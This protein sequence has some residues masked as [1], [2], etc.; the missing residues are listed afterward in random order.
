M[1]L[2]GQN[3]GIIKAVTCVMLSGA[4]LT[5]SLGPVSAEELGK[6]SSTQNS[7]ATMGSIPSVGDLS[8]PITAVVG[9]EREVHQRSKRVVPL[10]PIAVAAIA[11]GISIGVTGCDQSKHEHHHHYHN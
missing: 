7:M 11:A 9:D 4:V 6:I 3:K 1:K 8:L 10:V 2:F 5:Y